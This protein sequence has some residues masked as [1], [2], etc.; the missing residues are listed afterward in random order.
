MKICFF[1]IS[2]STNQDGAS[3]S[4]LNI[5][6]ELAERGNKIVLVL[7]SGANL[8]SIRSKKNIKCFIIPAFNMRVNLNYIT[9][10]TGVKFLDK[11]YM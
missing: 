7:S 3:L 5:A 8:E 11:I 4:M 6:C 10:T 2:S 9:R 1:S